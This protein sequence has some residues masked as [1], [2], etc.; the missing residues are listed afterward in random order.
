MTRV[1]TAVADYWETAK[2]KTG[3]AIKDLGN[4]LNTRLDALEKEQD[5]AQK[6]ADEDKK[7][8]FFSRLKD[9]VTGAW[10]WFRN[11][12]L[13]KWISRHIPENVKKRS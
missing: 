2:S 13:G 6:R 3:G 10:R 4:W 1:T 11:S 9:R 5:D 7:K 12:A 8:G